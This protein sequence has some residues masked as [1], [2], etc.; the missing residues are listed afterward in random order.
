MLK[1]R[2]TAV[3]YLDFNK[4][5][6]NLMR[7]NKSNYKVLHFNHGSPYYLYKLGN[8]RIEHSPAKNDL[9]NLVDAKLDT[10]QQHA[11]TAQKFSY[12]SIPGCIKRSMVSRLR[13][14]ILPFTLCW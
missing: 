13:E 11:L 12:P 14:V 1:R 8:K 10:S 3:I 6:K 9:V 5:Q 7:F 4:D 2:A